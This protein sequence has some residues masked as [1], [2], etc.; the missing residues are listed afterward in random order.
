MTVIGTNIASLRAGN[1]SNAA[2]N[3]L[4]RARELAVQSASGT[5]SDDDRT[6][7]QTEVTALTTQ[8]TSVLTNTQFNK[9]ALF[10]GSAG[11]SGDVTIQA[12]A[13]S[14]DTVTMTISAIDLSSATS[15]AISASSDAS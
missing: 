11:S 3:M 5:Y 6:N 7:L 4:Q 10:D 9:V 8:I 2:D 15:N 14:A 12:G 1:A 13:T